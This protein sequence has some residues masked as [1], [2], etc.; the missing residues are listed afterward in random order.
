[1][2]HICDYFETNRYICLPKMRA[3]ERKLGGAVVSALL[4]RGKKCV[5]LDEKRKWNLVRWVW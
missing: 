2:F 1:M 5:S 4:G 3:T